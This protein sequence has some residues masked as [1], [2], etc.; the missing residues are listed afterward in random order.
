MA[1]EGLSDFFLKSLGKKTVNA[2]EKMATNV[3]Q[4]LGTALEI[5]ANVGI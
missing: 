2:S 5:G 4:N 1:A 3:L